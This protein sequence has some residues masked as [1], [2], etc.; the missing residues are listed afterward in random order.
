MNPLLNVMVVFERIWVD[1]GHVLIDLRVV[2]FVYVA[3]QP[4]NAQLDV[5]RLYA[6]VH[7]SLD[8]DVGV[9]GAAVNDAVSWSAVVREL[10]HKW[11]VF[12]QVSVQEWVIN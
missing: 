6:P 5:L 11:A 9:Q 3:L 8:G 10:L 12:G 1:V 2:L 4:G 7:Q